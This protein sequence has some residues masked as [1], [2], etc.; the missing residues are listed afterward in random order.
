MA[1]GAD[2]HITL[3]DG[4]GTR[5]PRSVQCHLDAYDEYVEM[6]QKDPESRLARL[7]LAE[8]DPGTI[9]LFQ[10]VRSRARRFTEDHLKRGM[11]RDNNNNNN[12]WS[13][14]ATALIDTRRWPFHGQMISSQDA[15]DP[16]VGPRG[17]YPPPLDPAR[18][19]YWQLYANNDLPLKTARS[20]SSPTSCPSASIDERQFVLTSPVLLVGPHRITRRAILYLQQHTW[21]SRS[22]NCIGTPRIERK[23]WG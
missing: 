6:L 14:A 8:L 2:P 20:C 18:E 10:A 22:A 19:L 16:N 1:L 4:N 21:D 11:P 15:H 13:Q 9:K 3:S 7:M 17:E 5:I 12:T 23:I